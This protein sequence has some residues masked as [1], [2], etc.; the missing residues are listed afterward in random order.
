MRFFKYFGT[1]FREEEEVDLAS[2]E[3]KKDIKI[4]PSNRDT[5]EKD[6]LRKNTMLNAKR[7]KTGKYSNN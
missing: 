7:M 6:I 4:I 3:E 2:D 1:K 5:I